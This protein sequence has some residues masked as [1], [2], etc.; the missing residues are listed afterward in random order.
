M[1]DSAMHTICIIMCIM[2]DDFC[3]AKYLSF[4]YVS[5]MEW[6]VGPGSNEVDIGYMPLLRVVSSSS[7]A[8]KSELELPSSLIDDHYQHHTNVDISW[9]EEI[10]EKDALH[11]LEK[12]M[13]PFKKVHRC[14]YSIIQA[15]L[16]EITVLRVSTALRLDH[17]HEDTVS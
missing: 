8:W 10:T 13:Y 6:I 9:N 3:S 4:P 1:I 11:R 12:T 16:L 5:D 17:M 15:T 2:C 14:N 7:I